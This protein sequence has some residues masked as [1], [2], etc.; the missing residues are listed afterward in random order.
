MLTV[1]FPLWGSVSRL[2]HAIF[3]TQTSFV[4]TRGLLQPASW[5][6]TSVRPL[7]L[8]QRI[9]NTRRV[10]VISRLRNTDR[11]FTVSVV[12]WWRCNTGFL[13]AQLTE[14]PPAAAMLRGRLWCPSPATDQVQE[15]GRGGILETFFG[16]RMTSR[17][18]ATW[19]TRCIEKRKWRKM[20]MSR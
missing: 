3:P 11:P 1:D 4:L 16:L 6:S 20:K 12:I 8:P 5:P 19:R 17:T 2:E 9:L 7:F 15:Q 13:P 14:E 18:Q 10:S